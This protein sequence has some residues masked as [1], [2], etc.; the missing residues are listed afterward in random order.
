MQ[1]LFLCI[2]PDWVIVNRGLY[3]CD[4]CCSIHRSLGRHISQVKSLSADW[5]PVTLNVSISFKMCIIL[6]IVLWPVVYYIQKVLLLFY[7]W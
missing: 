7:R 4:E 6:L 2:D 5:C 3:I 1:F